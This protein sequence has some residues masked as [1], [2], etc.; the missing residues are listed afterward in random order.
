[1][2]NSNA[3]EQRAA[4]IKGLVASL[5]PMLGVGVACAGVAWS[6][7]AA[8]NPMDF[9]TERLAACSDGSTPN[10]AAAT[11]TA[12]YPCP[13]SANGGYLIPDNAAWAKLV[14]SYA[15]AITPSPMMPARTTGYGGFELALYGTITTIDHNQSYFQKGTQGAPG[16]VDG[17][18]QFP[19]ANGSV[20]PVLQ[21]YGIRG[22][23]GLPY[24]FEIEVNAAYMADTEMVALGGGFRWAIFEGF[25]KGISKYI[26]DV[27]IGGSVNTLTGSN[28]VKITVPTLDVLVSKPFVVANAVVLQP[29]LGFQLAWLLADSGVVDGTPNLDVL[30]NC[31][32]APPT[33]AQIAA[34]DNGDLHCQPKGSGAGATGQATTRLDL[35]NDMVFESLRLRTSRVSAG[36]SIRYEAI[37]FILHVATTFTDPSGTDDQRLAGMPHQLTAGF[38]TGLSW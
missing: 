10:I 33:P 25:R 1:M 29:Y 30:T 24:G 3:R 7:N 17:V 27:S 5:R 35:N 32:A 11:P 31:N 20:D 14:A 13:K 18:T 37:H 23:K 4:V 16:T 6:A 9:S 19:S 28:E 26:P 21:L 2:M 12:P 38:E 34:G 8:A 36:L 22:R 15:I